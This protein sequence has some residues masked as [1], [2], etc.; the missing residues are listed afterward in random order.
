MNL[1]PFIRHPAVSTANL[2]RLARSLDCLPSRLP[3]ECKARGWRCDCDD[4]WRSDVENAVKMGLIRDTL[5]ARAA[6]PIAGA[7]STCGAAEAA[8]NN[9]RFE[10]HPPVRPSP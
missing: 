3:C 2:E 8:R 6:R 5:R 9:S 7:D 10:D 4:E 1:F